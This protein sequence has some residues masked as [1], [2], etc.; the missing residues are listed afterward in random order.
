MDTSLYQ[1]SFDRNPD[2][3]WGSLL[4]AEEMK[5][6]EISPEGSCTE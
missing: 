5:R 6:E 4:N 3:N 1:K 2:R